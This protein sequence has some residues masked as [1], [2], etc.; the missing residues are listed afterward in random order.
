MRH[1]FT[2][3]GA[4]PISTRPYRPAPKTKE[5]Q[6]KLIDTLQDTKTSYYLKNVLSA[7]ARPGVIELMDEAIAAPNIKVCN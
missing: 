1:Y 7:S 6:T 4:W 3:D 5:E 2:K